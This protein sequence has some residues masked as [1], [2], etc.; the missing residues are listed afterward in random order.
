[1]YMRIDYRFWYG[2]LRLSRLNKLFYL[3]Q[4][5]GRYYTTR[6][7]QYGTFFGETFAFLAA[8]T[9]YIVVVLTALQ[10]GI[11]TRMLADSTAFDRVSAGFAIFSILGP[12]G[13]AFAVLLMFLYFFVDN[14]LATIRFREK[15]LR[16]IK[17]Q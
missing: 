7:Q 4:T 9:V 10:L 11:S 1:M 13:G 5:P 8:I 2:E 16:I 6:W 17:N 15:R 3:W 14:Y 12:F